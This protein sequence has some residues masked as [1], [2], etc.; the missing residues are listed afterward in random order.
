MWLKARSAGRYQKFLEHLVIFR[1]QIMVTQQS[2]VNGVKEA[3]DFL[4]HPPRFI[5]PAIKQV[6]VLG[7]GE[8]TSLARRLISHLECPACSPVYGWLEQRSHVSANCLGQHAWK[9][10]QEKFQPSKISRR[11]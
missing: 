6:Q 4:S 5:V 2:T 3:T 9:Q 10:P 11:C 7:S 1:H 8:E